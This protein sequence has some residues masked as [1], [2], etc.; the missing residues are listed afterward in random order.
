[1]QYSLYVVSQSETLPKVQIIALGLN[2][3]LRCPVLSDK[4]M[5]LK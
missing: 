3:A 5:E 1:M 2:L 4:R